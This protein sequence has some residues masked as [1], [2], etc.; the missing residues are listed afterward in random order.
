[1]NLRLRSAIIILAGGDAGSG[2][3]ALHPLEPTRQWDVTVVIPR[4][5][6]IVHAE[7]PGAAFSMLAARAA[8]WCAPCCW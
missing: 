8:A 7:N 3:Q 4:I 1:M 5:F 2:E 6:N